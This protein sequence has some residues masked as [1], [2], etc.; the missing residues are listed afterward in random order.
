MQV[1]FLPRCPTSL[2]ILVKF[3]DLPFLINLYIYI[4]DIVYPVLGVRTSLNILV[5]KI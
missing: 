4:L 2:N 5:N 1:A 3:N